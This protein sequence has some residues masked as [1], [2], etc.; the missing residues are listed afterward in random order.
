MLPPPVCR[1]H[2]PSKP[3]KPSGSV[4]HAGA[5]QRFCDKQVT[6]HRAVGVEVNEK[7]AVDWQE[8]GCNGF[9]V[10]QLRRTLNCFHILV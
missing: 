1:S 10:T 6:H 8:N 2:P 4:A 3:S 9:L 5:A 7:R